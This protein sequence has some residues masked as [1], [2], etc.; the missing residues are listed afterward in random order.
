MHI[1]TIGAIRKDHKEGYSV[2]AISRLRG[3]S[4]EEVAQALRKPR[5]KAY[6]PKKAV[7]HRISDRTELKIRTLMMDK[8]TP[9]EISKRLSM[10]LVTVSRIFDEEFDPSR[11]TRESGFSDDELCALYCG[12]KAG[13]VLKRF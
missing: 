13:G 12:H 8:L 11:F 6:K 9:R 10:S 5:K 7:Y 3:I 1:R 4:I 2:A